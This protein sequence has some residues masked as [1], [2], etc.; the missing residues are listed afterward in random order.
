M[1]GLFHRAEHLASARDNR[2][3][4]P[5]ASAL[6]L[7][8]KRDEDPLKAAHLAAL[9]YQ[10][11]ADGP[12]AETALEQFGKAELA[13]GEIVDRARCKSLLGWL[14]V[15]A[16][17]RK[18][19]NWQALQAEIMPTFV[20]AVS[21]MRDACDPLDELWQ[22]ATQLATG[23]VFEHESYTQMGAGAYRKGID[24]VI[25]P[26]GFLKGIVDV[27]SIEPT[28]ARQVSGAC[29][30]V[31]MAEMATHTGLDLWSYDNRGVSPV[32]ATT[33]LLYYYY[34]PEHW[35]WSD[36]L[37]PEDTA[38]VVASEGAFIEMVNR[39]HPLRGVE[40]LLAEMRP[41]FCASGGGLT[42]LTHGLAPPKKR[43]WRLL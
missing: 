15:A 1:N 3:R 9:R 41:M 24:H 19:A 36:G 30:L 38:A 8:D 10:M 34:Y 43:R 7:L 12:A 5:V 11:L 23:I 26:E 4:E 21:A 13:A 22:G 33:Y 35:R 16:M 2:E 27:E 29:A 17:L 18:H 39:R 14:S 37:S 25:H 32:T 20:A 42:T 40:Q 28:Y 6:P 31:I